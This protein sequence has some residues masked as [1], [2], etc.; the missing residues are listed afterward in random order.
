MRTKS[1]KNTRHTRVVLP[2]L[3]IA[4]FLFA[5][6]MMAEARRLIEENIV[7]RFAPSAERAM[8]YGNRYFSARAKNAYDIERAEYFYNQALVLDPQTPYLQHQLARIHFLKGDFNQALARIDLE[9]SDNPSV[10]PSSFYVRGLIEGYMGLYDAAASDYE[11]YLVQ[12]PKN[13][14]ALND[15]AWVLLKAGRF[16]DAR[17]VT[18]RALIDFPGNAWLLNSQAIA[19]FELG[20]YQEAFESAE[21][22]VP[23]VEALTEEEWLVA[24]PGND[25]RIAA[26]GIATLRNSIIHN[27]EKIAL[28]LSE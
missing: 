24:Y 13:W 16:E 18:T 26:E 14:A 25:P 12:D 11:K 7:F 8:T 2:I 15:Y 9:I 22:A 20:R 17:Q 21:K 3:A 1:L 10:S 28:R 23:A 4:V 6:G 5:S 19:L 27:K